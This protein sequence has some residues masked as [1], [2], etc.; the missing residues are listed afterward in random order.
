MGFFTQGSL[1]LHCTASYSPCRSYLSVCDAYSVVKGHHGVSLS[2]CLGKQA[3]SSCFDQRVCHTHPD[4]QRQH[5]NYMGNSSTM[6]PLSFRY[7]EHLHQTLVGIRKQSMGGDTSGCRLVVRVHRTWKRDVTLM[8][9]L[10]KQTFL[11]IKFTLNKWQSL[12]TTP[13][14][15]TSWM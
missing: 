5:G 4:T 7:K 2:I 15:L 14:W 13:W 1:S 8:W 9:K 11:S 6:A 10:F 3:L 12:T